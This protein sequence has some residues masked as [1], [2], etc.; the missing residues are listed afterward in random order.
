MLLALGWFRHRFKSAFTKFFFLQIRMRFPGSAVNWP[1]ISMEESQDHLKLPVLQ[2]GKCFPGSAI[3]GPWI[4]IEEFQEYLKVPF[5]LF[6]D[7]SLK[8][9]ACGFEMR[10]QPEEAIQYIEN[11]FPLVS[12]IFH[13]PGGW[14]RSHSSVITPSISGLRHSETF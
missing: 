2:I 6:M 12:H 7:D 5:E 8:Q 10:L 3:I 4:A 1:W 13:L 14:G 11:F 9:T